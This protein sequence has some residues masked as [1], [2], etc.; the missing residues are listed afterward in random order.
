MSTVHLDSGRQECEERRT[1]VCDPLVQDQN[2]H[3]LNNNYQPSIINNLMQSAILI[4]Q[5][6]LSIGL[7][8]CLSVCLSHAGVVKTTE[9]IIEQSTLRGSPEN[10]ILPS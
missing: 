4:E 6:C 2:V 3:R 10:L 9:P 7:S 5:C 8:V 1:Q